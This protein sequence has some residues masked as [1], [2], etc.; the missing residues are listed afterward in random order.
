M[1]RH[2]WFYYRIFTNVWI[3]THGRQNLCILQHWYHGCW[4]EVLV[5]KSKSNTAPKSPRNGTFNA[6]SIGHHWPV[7]SWRRNMMYLYARILTV[8][9][10]PWDSFYKQKLVVITA[11]IS[12]AFNFK[13]R[14]QISDVLTH[15]DF[16]FTKNTAVTS[17]EHV[18]SCVCMR[19]YIY[20]WDIYSVIFRSTH[21]S[22]L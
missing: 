12:N 2:V 21:G 20:C 10:A 3:L 9:L 18:E 5:S 22:A 6:K 16:S 7:I 13:Y 14:Y 1:L 8:F 4:S 11:R 15:T 17:E 19:L